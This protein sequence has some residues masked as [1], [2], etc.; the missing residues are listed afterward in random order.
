MRTTVRINDQLLTAAKQ[1]AA[2]S[3]HT[4]ASLIEDALREVLS[5]QQQ[6]PQRSRV[7]LKIVG[8]RGTRPGIDLNDSALLLE[9]MEQS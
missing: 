1:Y 7:K 5:R 6:S 3:G 8:G 4:L 2:Q 9:L